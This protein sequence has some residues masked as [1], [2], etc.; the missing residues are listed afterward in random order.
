MEGTSD[1]NRKE[2]KA[3]AALQDNKGNQNDRKSRLDSKEDLSG[4]GANR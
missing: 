3:A 2:T 4:C 1:D